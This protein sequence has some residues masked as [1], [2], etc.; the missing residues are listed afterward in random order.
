MCDHHGRTL[1]AQFD[2][3]LQLFAP[4]CNKSFLKGLFRDF[5]VNRLWSVGRPQF[6]LNFF[7]RFQVRANPSHSKKMAAWNALVYMRWVG[8]PP[9]QITV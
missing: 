8:R 3:L 4:R 7:E 9:I 5:S 2:V 6:A 1:I